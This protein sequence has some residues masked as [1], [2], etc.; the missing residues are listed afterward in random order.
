MS[1][2]TQRRI[3]EL[4][5]PAEAMTAEQAEDAMGGL[6]FVTRIN[7][8]S[9]ILFLTSQPSGVEDRMELEAGALVKW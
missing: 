4:A 6:S 2:T 7:K 3:G 5:R 1:E 9:P 8:A